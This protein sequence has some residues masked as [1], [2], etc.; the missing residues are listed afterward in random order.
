MASATPATAARLNARFRRSPFGDGSGR[1]GGAGPHLAASPWPTTG[2]LADAGVLVHLFDGFEAHG[3]LK[4]LPVSGAESISA[5]LVYAQQRAN[6]S[7]TIPTFNRGTL[8]LVL[9]PNFHLV[10]CGCDSDCGGRCVGAFG[11]GGAPGSGA[12]R[13]TSPLWCPLTTEAGEWH[14]GCVWQPGPALGRMLYLNQ[15]S[16]RY[17]EVVVS[18]AFWRDHMPSAVEAVL[19]DEGVHAAFLRAYGLS[20]R[21]VPL[22]TM[23]LSDFDSPFRSA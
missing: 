18:A 23:D 14:G 3:G 11:M 9:R 15:R 22:L 2:L 17:N 1:E 16:D 7:K 4:W 13:A 5:S 21:D 19:G 6:P 12:P 10:Q 20:S 8:G